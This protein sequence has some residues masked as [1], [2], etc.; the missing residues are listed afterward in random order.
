MRVAVTVVDHEFTLPPGEPVEA[1]IDA[2]CGVHIYGCPNNSPMQITQYVLDVPGAL[3]SQALLWS[4]LSKFLPSGSPRETPDGELTAAAD[5]ADNPEKAEYVDRRA[6]EAAERH[7]DE[8]RTRVTAS[9]LPSSDVIAEAFNR[10][11]AEIGFKPPPA[12]TLAP[13]VTS[14]K[15]QLVVIGSDYGAGSLKLLMLSLNDDTLQVVPLPCWSQR[16]RPSAEATEQT[17]VCSS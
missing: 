4:H 16:A 17:V 13:L 15:V 5:L 1:V 10:P 8:L 3:R 12:A 11:P 2:F 7:A 14:G 9:Q 6:E